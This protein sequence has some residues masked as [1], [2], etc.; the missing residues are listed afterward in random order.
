M[1]AEVA[2]RTRHRPE[3]GPGLR[4]REV[5]ALYFGGGTANLTPDAFAELG[6]S[7]AEAFDLRRAELSLEGAPIYFLSRHQAI[8][9][10]FAGIPARHRRLSMGVQTFD[11]A[12]LA[13]MGRA[14]FG[15]REQVAEVVR[16]AHARGMTVSCDL[17]INLPG[18]GWEDQQR[19]LETAL[20]LGFD[21]V[22]VYHLVLFRGVGT[23]WAKDPELLGQLPDNALACENWR[24]ARAFLLEA[25][26]VQASLTNFERGALHQSERRFRYEE[27]SFTP[28]ASDAV[29]FGPAAISLTHHEVVC[30]QQTVKQ[31]NLS[32]AAAYRAAVAAHG[33]ADARDFVYAFEDREL[34]HLTRTLPRLAVDRTIYRS[35]FGADLTQSFATELRALEQAELVRLDPDA[36]RLTERGMFYADSVAGLLA[37]RRVTRLRSRRRLPSG[38]N[39]AGPVH[40]G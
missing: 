7:L 23:E 32:D 30:Q 14:H 9:D 19:D 22:C 26:F 29:G 15:E 31:V 4:G 13:R 5:E 39:D 2:A 34:L 33:A 28:H 35:E 24:R 18:Q 27:L 21:Q 38:S 12:W 20:S 25:G 37:Q 17:M 8:L 16:A 10:A 40:M 6:A 1:I 11:P 3:F 36:L